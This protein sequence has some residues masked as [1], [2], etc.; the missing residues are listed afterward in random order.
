MVGESMMSQ[1]ASGATAMATA[2][3]TEAASEG[4]GALV[5]KRDTSFPK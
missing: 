5:E 4:L 2:L 1:L 3:T